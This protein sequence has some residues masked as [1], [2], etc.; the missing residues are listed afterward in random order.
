MRA[1]SVQAA[2]SVT[3]LNFIFPFQKKEDY[4]L[5]TACMLVPFSAGN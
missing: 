5:N 2:V 1:P 4:G 3:L